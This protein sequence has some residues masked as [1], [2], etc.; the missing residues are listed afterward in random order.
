MDTIRFGA[1]ERHGAAIDLEMRR[2]APARRDHET[3]VAPFGDNAFAHEL[4][5]HIVDD[6]AELI[7][8]AFGE[9]PYAVVVDGEQLRE[10]PQRF[11]VVFADQAQPVLTMPERQEAV[12]AVV[13]TEL[14]VSQQTHGADSW[15]LTSI[16]HTIIV[17]S[18]TGGFHETNR[19][20]CARHFSDCDFGTRAGGM[21]RPCAGAG[22]R[23]KPRDQPRH[24]RDPCRRADRYL[25]GLHR[26]GPAAHADAM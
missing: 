26:E 21:R 7:E 6:L 12:C 5:G 25:A 17:Q 16:G 2:R 1:E 10:P 3:L 18:A 22:L 19:R 9:K 20:F 24:R 4:L 13:V 8:A 14:D 11:S 15:V 23:A